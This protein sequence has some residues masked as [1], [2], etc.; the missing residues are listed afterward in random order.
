MTD[1]SLLRS[2]AAARQVLAATSSDQLGLATPCEKWSVADLIDHLVGAQNW[3]YAGLTGSDAGSAAG[4]WSGDYV[5]AFDESAARVL[6][7][8]DDAEVMAK[9]VNPGFGDMPAPALIGMITSD[10]LVHAW[11]LAVATGQDRDLDPELAEQLLARAKE[12][13]PDSFRDPEGNIFGLEQDAPVNACAADR[14]AAFLGRTV[15]S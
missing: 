11:D 8:T 10:T 6:A 5:T 12:S 3:G 4:V 9:T 13:I 15:P 2:H 14:L 1:P 7:L